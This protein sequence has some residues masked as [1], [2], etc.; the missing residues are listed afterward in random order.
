MKTIKTSKGKEVLVDDKH[1]EYLSKFKWS[2]NA[3]GY[4]FR[5]QYI[6]SRQQSRETGLSRKEKR[7]VLKDRPL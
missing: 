4:A 2:I 3:L 7:P 1:Y 5:T 6:M